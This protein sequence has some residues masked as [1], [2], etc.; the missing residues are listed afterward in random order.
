MISEIS[1]GQDRSLQWQY[2]LEAGADFTEYPYAV[3]PLILTETGVY[4]LLFL[5]RQPDCE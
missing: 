3:P 5:P 1:F 2:L 4:P